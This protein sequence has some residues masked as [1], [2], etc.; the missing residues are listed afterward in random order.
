MR[1]LNGTSQHGLWFPKGRACSLVCFSYSCFTGYKSD[2]KST[3]GTCHLFANCLV[4][5]HSKKRHNI[6]LCTTE[7]EYAT[8]GS[9]CAQVL[10]LK[11]KFLE[12]DLKLGC[13]RIKCDNTSAIS[14]AKNLVLHSRSKHRNPTP[15]S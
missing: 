5:W 12:D 6:S 15:L 9:C 8:V 11:Q 10:W 4:S 13:I 14:L 3:S 7:A 2:R 1:Y